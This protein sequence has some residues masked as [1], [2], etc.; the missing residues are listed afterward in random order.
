MRKYILIFLIILSTVLSGCSNAPVDASGKISTPKITTAPLQGKWIVEKGFDKDFKAITQKNAAPL[1]DKAAEFTQDGI[2]VG[3]FF[4]T[5]P[6]YKIKKAK[7]AEYFILKYQKSPEKLGIQDK[8]ITVVTVTSF[9]RFIYEFVKI[10]ENEC[11]AEI[12]GC[13]YC[14][15]KTSD[16]VDS[17]FTQK[18]SRENVPDNNLDNQKN[19]KIPISGVFVGLKSFNSSHGS[20]NDYSYRTIFIESINKSI[21]TV[22]QTDNIFFPRRSGFWKLEVKKVSSGNRTEDIISA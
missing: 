10:N 6:E 14:L 5:N 7:S 16:Q 2:M 15:R 22:M 13:L 4:W 19:D 3:N 21:K 12:D 9:E 8:D 18:I 17:D 1:I 11:L 20:D